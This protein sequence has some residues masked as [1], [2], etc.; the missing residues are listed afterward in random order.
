[1]DMLMESLV[2]WTGI[3][4]DACSQ[5]LTLPA[6]EDH[7]EWALL[8]SGHKP[9]LKLEDRTQSEVGRWWDAAA[10]N[11][12]SVAVVKRLS[13]PRPERRNLSSAEGKRRFDVFVAPRKSIVDELADLARK[14]RASG[15]ARSKAIIR[16]GELLGYPSCCAEFMAGLPRQDD[17]TVMSA[18]RQRAAGVVSLPS[19][20]LNIFPPLV[21]PVTWYPCSLHCSATLEYANRVQTE[22]EI[23]EPAI[24]SL[25]GLTLVFGRFLFVHLVNAQL[26]DGWWLYEG[27]A[28][29]LSFASE[30]VVLDSQHIRSF[31]HQVTNCFAQGSACG[32]EGDSVRV[33]LPQNEATGKML[34]AP[35]VVYS[36][37]MGKEVS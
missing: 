4:L 1:M 32:I 6:P 23:L 25:A 21:S 26:Q 5:A 19:P 20:L 9:A 13:G 15:D 37:G 35:L 11:R 24:A 36:H 2:E 17:D 30:A 7:L 3:S 22:T 18:Y 34:L 8:L 10:A 16:S 12:F 33:R 31:R 14:E 29:A 27:V 28:D